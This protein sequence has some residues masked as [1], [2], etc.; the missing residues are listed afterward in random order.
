[1]KRTYSELIKLPTFEERYRYLRIGG[2]VGEDTFGH[3]KRTHS[4]MLECLIR[5]STDRL[6]GNGSEER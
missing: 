3:A 6:N 1:M 2:V 4:G 5:Y